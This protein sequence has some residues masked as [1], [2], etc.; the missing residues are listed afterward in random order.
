MKNL[1]ILMTMAILVLGV[2]MGLSNDNISSHNPDNKTKIVRTSNKVIVYK[3]KK[4]QY[5]NGT[6]YLL[7]GRRLVVTRPPVGAKISVLPRNSKVVV[8]KG[9]K[10]FSYNGTYYKKKGNKFIVVRF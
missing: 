3:G 6:W 4:Y 2:N 5:K 8:I 10:Y 9:K 1:R 7:R